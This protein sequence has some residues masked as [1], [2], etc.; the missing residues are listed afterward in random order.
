MNSGSKKEKYSLLGISNLKIMK[1]N[2]Y[3][4]FLLGTL[5]MG[6]ALKGAAQSAS[7]DRELKKATA[8]YNALQYAYAIPSLE[9]VLEKDSS[10]VKAQ[11]CLQLPDGQKL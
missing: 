10:N 5:L 4:S 9:K 3:T 1:S 6:L 11:D 8:N 7:D 2:I